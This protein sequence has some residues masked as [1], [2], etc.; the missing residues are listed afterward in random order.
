VR[1]ASPDTEP[2]LAAIVVAP[3]PALVV[4][5]CLLI[6]ATLAF[7]EVQF[8]CVVRSCMVPSLKLPVAA[9]DADAP[10]TMEG[11]AGVTAIETRVAFVTVRFAEPKMEPKMA[12]IVVV[13]GPWPVA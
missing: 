5:P 2:K 11:F 12:M 6:T 4:T 10:K 3:V 8:T 13:P 9:N 1:D 7:A